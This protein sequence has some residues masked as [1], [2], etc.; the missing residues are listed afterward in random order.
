MLAIIFKAFGC[1]RTLS[2]TQAF[3][4]GPMRMRLTR[5][6]HRSSGNK[7]SCWNPQRLTSGNKGLVSSQD[8]HERRQSQ[9][10]F[11]MI[12]EVQ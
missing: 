8:R 5:C 10:C 1:I 12:F 11:C 2:H 3:R 4:L 7:R 9:G 6:L